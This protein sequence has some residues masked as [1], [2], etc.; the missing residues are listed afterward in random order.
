MDMPA[1]PWL[2]FDALTQLAATATEQ[3]ACTACQRLLRPG[4]ES[5]AQT[6]D[7]AHL[8]ACGT[9]RDDPEREPSLSEFH[10]RGT[11]YW[12]PEAPIAPGW[13]PYNRC[14]LW[15][16]GHCRHAFLRYTE[17]GGYYQE[18]RIRALQ[19]GLLVDAGLP[20]SGM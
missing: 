8:Q 10:P 19:L 9:L 5:L 6:D 7:A 3:A 17:Y 18:A 11:R 4:W 15:Q 12:S 14:E 20:D 16:C 2:D 1:L 13:F